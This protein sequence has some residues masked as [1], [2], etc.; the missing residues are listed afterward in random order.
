MT[1]EFELKL[2]DVTLMACRADG[3]CFVHFDKTWIGLCT[4]CSVGL[5]YFVV[6]INEYTS[7]LTPLK[8]KLQVK[9]ELSFNPIRVTLRV[10]LQVPLNL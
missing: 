1:N 10:L 9:F 8:N 4:V 2:D 3:P 6:I 7:S 5:C